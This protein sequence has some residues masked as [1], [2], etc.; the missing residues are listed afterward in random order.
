MQD[1]K[2]RIEAI[3]FT[4]GK[5]MN[6]EELA[7]FCHIG[8]V[9]SVKDA[10]HSLI[11]DYKEKD[12]A[13]EIFEENGKYKL[14]IK[15]AYNYLTTN[16]LNDSEL[17]KPTQE[18][19]AIIAYRNPALQSDIIK[20]RGNGAYDHI[21]RLKEIGFVVSEKYGRTRKVK[22]TQKFFDYFDIVDETQLGER[23]KAI[24]EKV[25]TLAEKKE[26]PKA[27]EARDEGEESVEVS[28]TDKA[29]ESSET[30]E[31][32]SETNEA[33]EESPE[34]LEESSETPEE[35]SETDGASED[36][37][38]TSES[39]EEPTNEEEPETVEEESNPAA[40]EPVESTAEETT[41]EPSKEEEK[42]E[43]GT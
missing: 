5:F 37:G 16:L 21:K 3:L 33:S 40:K 8:S 43:E 20:L 31:K 32:P 26:D 17:D 2:N 30:S 9:G 38:E 24:A 6:M 39:T 25:R 11:Q 1:I 36:S 34:V 28:E 22:L 41:E 23:F 7:Q 14:N 10:L 27:E 4:T 42:H 35:S 12:S 19:L 15:K 29:E 18:T 13:L